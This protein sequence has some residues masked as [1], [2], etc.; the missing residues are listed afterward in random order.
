MSKTTNKLLKAIES[1]EEP[2]EVSKY[3]IFKK[4]MTSFCEF[5]NDIIKFAYFAASIAGGYIL[6]QQ[7]DNN[8]R[9]IGIIMLIGGI[10]FFASKTIRK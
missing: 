1:P 8:I 4:K 2:L 10:I 3:K 9:I 6:V 7:A 5:I